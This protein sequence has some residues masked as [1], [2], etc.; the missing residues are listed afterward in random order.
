LAAAPD[1]K[2]THLPCAG[3][4]GANSVNLDHAREAVVAEFKALAVVQSSASSIGPHDLL[5][6]GN[7]IAAE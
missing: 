3:F 5:P 1:L 6:A 4:Q 2:N 7:L